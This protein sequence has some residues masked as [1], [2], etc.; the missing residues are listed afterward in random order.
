[1]ALGLGVAVHSG[2]SV[3]YRIGVDTII[4]RVRG[5]AVAGTQAVNA[6]RNNMAQQAL[7]GPQYEISDAW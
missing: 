3:G 4:T 5:V 7:P 1:V 6:P 2:G